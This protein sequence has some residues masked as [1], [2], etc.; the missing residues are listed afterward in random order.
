MHE[1]YA[2]SAPTTSDAIRA[3]WPT[4]EL[5][6]AGRDW[7]TGYNVVAALMRSARKLEVQSVGRQERTTWAGIARAYYVSFGRPFG[8]FAR[9][10][11]GE[12][13]ALTGQAVAR[14]TRSSTTTSAL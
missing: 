11:S 9:L 3:C 14:E 6:H 10:A 4:T 12:A 8:P 1:R 2:Q 7:V 5:V 13:A